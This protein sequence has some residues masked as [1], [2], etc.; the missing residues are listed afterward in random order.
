MQQVLLSIPMSEFEVNLGNI[1]EQAVKRALEQKEP[2]RYYSM[3]E[4]VKRTGKSKSTLYTDHSRGRLHGFKC[5]RQVR[6]TEEQLV[7]YLEGR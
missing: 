7:N 4:A 1:V 2:V 3:N 6:F 5:G